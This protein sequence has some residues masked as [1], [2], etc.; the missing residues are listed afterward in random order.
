VVVV[1]ALYSASAEDLLIV[2]CFFDFQE[3]SESQKKTEKLVTLLLMS[4][5]PP[6]SLSEYAFKCKLE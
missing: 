2:G 5:Q 3:I 1:K 4:R 6:Q